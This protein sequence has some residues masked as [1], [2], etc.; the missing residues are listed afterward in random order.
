M[1]N[2]S[3]RTNLPERTPTILRAAQ[4]LLSELALLLSLLG[5]LHNSGIVLGSVRTRNVVESEFSK[6]WDVAKRKEAE[7][8]EMLIGSVGDYGHDSEVR[9]AGVVDEAGWSGHE[10]TVNLVG[11]ISQTSVLRLGVAELVQSEEI[12]VLAV[13]SLITAPIGLLWSQ[14]LTNVFVDELAFADVLSS[15]Y[16][17][18][19]C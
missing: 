17:C 5:L 19:G 9:V 16:S 3:V 1:C 14:D 12:Q 7:L 11:F 2:T 4:A 15:A 8:M 6:A 10:F 13:W 18:K